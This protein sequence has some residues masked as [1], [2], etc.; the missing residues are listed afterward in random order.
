[1][2]DPLPTALPEQVTAQCNHPLL[3]VCMIARNEEGNL[4]SCLEAIRGLAD[5]IVLVDTGSSDGT[6]EIARSFGARV[7]E[8]GWHADFAAPRNVAA[9]HARGQWILAIDAD[10]VV[11]P[12]SR[13]RLRQLLSDESVGAYY[14]LMRRRAGLTPN[15]HM[16]LYRNHPQLRHTCLI[17][18]GITPGQVRAQTGKSLGRC[19]LLLHHSGYEGDLTH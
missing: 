19:R 18:E 6:R 5:E 4:P 14:V 15:W 10:E 3:T 13:S 12:Y 1:M 16:R 9:R 7:Y 2:N 11:Q 17:H 8:S